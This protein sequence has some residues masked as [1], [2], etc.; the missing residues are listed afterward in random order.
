MVFTDRL[1]LRRYGNEAKMGTVMHELNVGDEMQF[2]GPNQQWAYERNKYK[3]IYMLA[4]GTG[5]ACT[6]PFPVGGPDLNP[7][8][9]T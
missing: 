4:G 2:K 3:T 7:Y 1:L 5:T 8:D 9:S 6:D